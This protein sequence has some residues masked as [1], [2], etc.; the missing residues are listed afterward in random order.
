MYSLCSLLHNVSLDSEPLYSLNEKGLIIVLA[1]L[2]GVFT[3]LL[4][5][6]ATIIIIQKVVGVFQKTDEKDKKP[7]E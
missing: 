4:L 1:G 7:A 5:F 2:A 3:I 6:F